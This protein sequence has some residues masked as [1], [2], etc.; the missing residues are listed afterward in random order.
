MSQFTDQQDSRMYE[1]QARIIS[2]LR[3]QLVETTKQKEH[4]ISLVGYGTYYRIMQ[5]AIMENETLQDEWN[6]FVSMLKLC[7]PDFEEKMQN[8]TKS[9]EVIWSWQ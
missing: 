7:V 6:R 9:Q 8:L 5:E 2:N 3:Q 1:A 4:L